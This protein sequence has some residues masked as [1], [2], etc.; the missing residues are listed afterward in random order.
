MIDPG[1]FN[2]RQQRGAPLFLI[3]VSPSEP[4]AKPQVSGDRQHPTDHWVLATSTNSVGDVA[5]TS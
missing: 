3:V 4:P 5:R 2:D 1:S